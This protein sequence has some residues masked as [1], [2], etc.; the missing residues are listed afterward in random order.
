M[1][2]A[3]GPT[4]RLAAAG[5]TKA[6]RPRPR[7]FVACTSRRTVHRHATRPRYGASTP[8]IKPVAAICGKRRS[9]LSLGVGLARVRRKPVKPTRGDTESAI[10]PFGSGRPVRPWLVVN[11]GEGM[12]TPWA[13]WPQPSSENNFPAARLPR[14]T[15]SFASVFSTVLRPLRGAASP[16]PAGG[17]QQG[18]TGAT[19]FNPK[20][21]TSW[22][23]S[24]PSPQRKTASPASSAPGPQRQGQADSQRQGRHRERPRLPPSGGRPRH[25]R[26]VEEDQRS[27]AALRVRIL[28][29]PS[30]PA[31]VYARLIENED[32]THDLIWSRS[33]PKAA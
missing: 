4:P 26:G 25:R 27:R 1:I 11:P 16:S 2:G 15:N 3:C 14:G 8:R 28:D 5:C 18:R 32:S 22:L 21:E 31:T 12:A 20:G 9:R 17:S 24:A 13:S 23:T 29:D 7:Q 10:S 30:F 6:C 33:K 19:L